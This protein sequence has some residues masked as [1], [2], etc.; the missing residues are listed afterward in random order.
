MIYKIFSKGEI[1]IVYYN[2]IGNYSYVYKKLSSQ[3]KRVSLIEITSTI[4]VFF[5][6]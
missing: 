1:H 3:K 5:F 2:K 6:Y 4:G